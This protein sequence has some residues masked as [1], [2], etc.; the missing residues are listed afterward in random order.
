MAMPTPT[1]RLEQRRSPLSKCRVCVWLDTLS[2]ADR[3]EW[4]KAIEDARFSARMIATEVAVDIV[5]TQ[6]AG[7]T[8]GE[9]SI[10][11]HRKSRHP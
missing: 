10:V 4:Q 6:Y 2:P 5:A 8:I 7:L 3:A 11:G 1:E 9:S